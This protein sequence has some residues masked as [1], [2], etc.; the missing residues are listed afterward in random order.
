MGGNKSEVVDVWMYGWIDGW[1][2]GWRRS[3]VSQGQ[4]LFLLP[5]FSPTKLWVSRDVVYSGSSAG[6]RW[7]TVE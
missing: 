5:G 2:S 3:G 7:S 6:Q 1:V 4:Q